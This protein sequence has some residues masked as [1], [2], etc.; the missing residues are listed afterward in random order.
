M[1]CL[2][3]FDSCR[4]SLLLVKTVCIMQKKIAAFLFST[5]LMGVLFISYFVAM[6]IG[7]FLDV[8]QETSPTPYSRYWIYD[9]WWFTGIH[10]MFVINFLGNIMRFK[11]LRKEKITTLI[12]HLS[13]YPLCTDK[14]LTS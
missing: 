9:T 10:I 12:F 3:L 1:L 11:L 4:L 6:I 13:F 2:R 7:T 5:R 14:H 8:G